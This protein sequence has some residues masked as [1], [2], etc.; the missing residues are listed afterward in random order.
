[1]MTRLDKILFVAVL[2]LGSSFVTS[3]ILGQVPAFRKHR[4]AKPTR[5]AVAPPAAAP[6]TR[7]AGAD[8]LPHET[9]TTTVVSSV[10]TDPVTIQKELEAAI[11]RPL[12]KGQLGEYMLL[13]AEAVADGR[14]VRINAQASVKDSRKGVFFLWSLLV[15]HGQDNQVVRHIFYDAQM[16]S[17]GDL[18]SPVV[19]FSE[20][21]V[22]PPGIYRVDVNLWAVSKTVDIKRMKVDLAYCRQHSALRGIT[23]FSVVE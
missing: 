4:P 2:A 10:I 16:F 18:A 23:K 21:L 6:T 11:S 5:S 20:N 7:L 22:L 1:M 9:G 17:V 13:G 8:S 14:N 3:T 15:R 19:T 12:A